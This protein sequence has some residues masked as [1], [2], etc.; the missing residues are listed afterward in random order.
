MITKKQNEANVLTAQVVSQLMCCSSRLITD[1]VDAVVAD[2]L[3]L[4]HD[5]KKKLKKLTK[6]VDKCAVAKTVKKN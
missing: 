1:D 2:M 6:P 4:T 3:K 5:Y